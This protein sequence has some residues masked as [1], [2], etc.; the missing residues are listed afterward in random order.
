MSIYLVCE[1]PTDG[2]D[3]R[4]LNLLI[5]N[6]LGREVLIEPVGGDGSV[7]SVASWLEERSRIQRSDGTW[8]RPQDRVYAVADRNYRSAKEAEQIWNHRSKRRWLWR[9]HEIENYLLDPRVVT[10]AFRSF[11]ATGVRGAENLPRDEQ[12]VFAQL[13][14]L[15][16]PMLDT[17]AGWLTYWHLNCLKN[18]EA[19]D[20]RLLKP[21]DTMPPRSSPP[22][23]RDEW[24]S[25]LRL[26]GLRLKQACAH[27]IEDSTFDESAVAQMYDGILA[28]I[29]QPDFFSSGQFLLDLGGHELM[30]ALCAYINRKGVSHL[31]DSDL[32]TELINALDR[33]YAPG[34]F[35]PDD[36][37]ELARRLI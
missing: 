3:M 4:M 6:K 30:S 26:E 5:V 8:S 11:D 37:D 10:E 21:T 17:H 15:A 25:Y 18:I 7:G 34:F 27:L 1:G 14:Q 20:T 31:S 33:L 24:L 22:K 36:F 9:R 32:E 29:T 35:V 16:Q 13:Q 28:R 2:L 23:S 12:V 19:N